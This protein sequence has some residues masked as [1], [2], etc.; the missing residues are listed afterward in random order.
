[1]PQQG[2]DTLAAQLQKPHRSLYL[3]D[4]GG[5]EDKA[6]IKAACRMY[7]CCVSGGAIQCNTLLRLCSTDQRGKWSIDQ[8]FDRSRRAWHAAPRLCSW[9]T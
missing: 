1:M 2:A 9:Q 4:L 8:P 7:P 6:A 5:E 3:V